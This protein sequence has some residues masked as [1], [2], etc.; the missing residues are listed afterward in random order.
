MIFLFLR[1]SGNEVNRGP[2]KI[3]RRDETRAASD[4]R[5]AREKNWIDADITTNRAQAIGQS[6][7]A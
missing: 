2:I 3:D 6:L 1:W 7:T 4:T 5:D